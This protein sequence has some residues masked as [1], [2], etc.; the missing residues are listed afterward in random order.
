[1]QWTHHVRGQRK[2]VC[3]GSRR[4]RLIYVCVAAII[5]AR[6]Q[7]GFILTYQ[8]GERTLDPHALIQLLGGQNT[9]RTKLALAVA[10]F[11]LLVTVPLF[12]HHSFSSEYE[13]SKV[14]TLT[15]KMV[16][17]E[18][19]NPHSWIHVEVTNPDGS[20][21]EWKGETPPINVHYRNGWTKPMVEE[22]VKKGEI[23]ELSGQAAK[24]GSHHL[25]ASGVKRSDGVTVLGLN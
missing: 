15:G 2:A 7:N 21:T 22:M 17:F 18:W 12:A 11:A 14:V 3:V 9:M 8:S 5:I 24:D 10:A 13:S 23:V 19:L 20:K 25:F 1:C 16:N 4:K 6:L